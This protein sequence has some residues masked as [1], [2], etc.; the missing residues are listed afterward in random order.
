MAASSSEIPKIILP[1][2]TSNPS[3]WL[4]RRVL[5]EYNGKKHD[6]ISFKYKNGKFYV[7][8]DYWMCFFLKD[9]MF[10]KNK[11]I[12]DKLSQITT[13]TFMSL[14]DFHDLIRNVETTPR[15]HVKV[16]NFCNYLTEDFLMKEF[17]K[18]DHE[19]DEYNINCEFKRLDSESCP[20]Y[21]IKHYQEKYPDFD[22]EQ[23][24]SHPKCKQYFEFYDFMK[25]Q[26]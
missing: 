9:K 16:D 23:L 22:I 3:S 25:T 7:E 14:D 26:E 6:N 20:I 21:L 8:M 11:D 2:K 19:S 13:G 18:R 10:Q 24:R 15:I 17:L 1:P 4:T 12:R 5:Y